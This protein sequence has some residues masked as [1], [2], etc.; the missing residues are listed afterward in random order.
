MPVNRLADIERAI[1]ELTREEFEELCLWFEAH[2]GPSALDRRIETDLASG[3]LD[4]AI[5][6]ALDDEKHSRVRSL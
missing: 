4:K 6:R 5:D 3:R 2:S 1:G